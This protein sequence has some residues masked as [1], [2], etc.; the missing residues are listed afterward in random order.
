MRVVDFPTSLSSNSRETCLPTIRR[1]PPDRFG[2]VN[3][4]PNGVGGSPRR[5]NI[6]LAFDLSI[7]FEESYGAP[8]NFVNCVYD[9]FDYS[10]DMYFSGTHSP[11]SSIRKTLRIRSGKNGGTS[12]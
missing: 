12:S 3:T 8:F 4:R 2:E 11:S 6:T 7:V 5:P 10:A 1:R 9:L